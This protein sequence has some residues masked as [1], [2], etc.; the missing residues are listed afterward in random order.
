VN[1]TDGI[2][3]ALYDRWDS[4]G[5]WKGS[6]LELEAGTYEETIDIDSDFW[7]IKII[8]KDGTATIH[9]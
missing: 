5:A 8:S 3:Y 4:H 1:T 2:N 6:I 7:P 9:P